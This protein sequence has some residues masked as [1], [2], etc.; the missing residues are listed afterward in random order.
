M[1]NENKKKKYG[2]IFF[3][4]GSLCFGIYQEYS[5]ELTGWSLIR[6][7]SVD[8]PN[9]FL[10]MHTTALA[11]EENNISTELE[12]GK[13]DIVIADSQLTIYTEIAKENYKENVDAENGEN[14]I[15]LNTAS[16]AE[17]DKLPGIGPVKAQAIIDYR[18]AKG[19]FAKKSEIVNVS[20]I[21][22]ATYEKIKGMIM[23]D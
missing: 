15:N 13:Q 22:Q 14:C 11:K 8:M 5:K 4:L 23:V 9:D 10:D 6:S 19:G 18:N 3:L 20:G 16:L 1:T 2:I 21:G 17:L 7:L 12:I